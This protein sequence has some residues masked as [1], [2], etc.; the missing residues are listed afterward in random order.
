MSNDFY[1]EPIDISVP[2]LSRVLKEKGRNWTSLKE[3]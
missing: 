3:V 1:E 2:G